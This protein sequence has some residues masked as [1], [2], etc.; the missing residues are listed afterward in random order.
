MNSLLTILRELDKNYYTISDLRMI[1]KLPLDSLYVALS[2][3][4]KNNSLIRLTS[5]IYI[6]AD[7]YNKID[8]IANALYQPSYLSFETA[9]SRYGILSQVPY[10][11]TFATSRKSLK[12]KL[13]DVA[14]E[15]RKLKSNLFFGYEKVDSLFIAAP[16]KAFLDTLYLISFGKLNINIDSLDLKEI[17]LKKA[18]KISLQYPERTKQLFKKIVC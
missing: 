9:L 6:L 12:K 3:L 14:V 4:S 15:Y 5:G 11:L 2:R 18:K 17:D 16:E 13:G 1:T 7:K 10:L 8:T